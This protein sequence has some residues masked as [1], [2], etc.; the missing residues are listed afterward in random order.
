[1]VVSSETVLHA[2]V[3]DFGLA[4]YRGEPSVL[5]DAAG[6][7][8][9]CAPEQLR[10]QQCLP[11]TDIYAWA[12]MFVEC[13]TAKPCIQGANVDEILQ[14]QLDPSAIALPYELLGSPLAALLKKSLHKDV[15]Q[16]A[17]DAVQLHGELMHC[18]ALLRNAGADR[19]S[20]GPRRPR[21]TPSRQVTADPIG[22]AP[23]GDLSTTFRTILCLTLRLYPTDEA[24]MALSDLKEMREQQMDWCTSAVR[25]GHGHGVGILGDCLLFHFE[26][27]TKPGTSHLE[28]VAKLA[29]KLC[30][31][32]DRRSRILEVQRGVRLEVSG[33]LHMV[34][35]T[36]PG[37]VSIANHAT[38]VAL[39]LSGLTAPGNVV[40]SSETQ[41]QLAGRMPTVLYTSARHAQTKPFYRLV[42]QPSP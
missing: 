2:K 31:R 13:L 1:M 5:A 15:H 37:S 29:L 4:T 9:Y 33:A 23:R 26:H 8:A 27:N 19:G 32:M 16:R 22:I 42:A 3:L 7:P 6:T 17:G 20:S 30:A 24:L 18:L 25:D 38:N 36:A 21:L 41:A 39:H 35:L 28:H 40:I 34:T 14:N 10:G 11:A 12:L